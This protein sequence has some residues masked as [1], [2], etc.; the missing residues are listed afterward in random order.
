MDQAS[1][2]SMARVVAQGDLRPMADNREAMQDLRQILTAREGAY[3]RADAQLDTSG[4]TLAQSAGELVELA[5][6]LLDQIACC[7]PET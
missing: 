1:P 6:R 7:P 3:G 2:E 4:R 5:K